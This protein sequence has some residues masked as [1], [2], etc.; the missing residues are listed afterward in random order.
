M[1]LDWLCTRGNNGICYFTLD[2]NRIPHRSRDLTEDDWD[3]LDALHD[4]VIADPQ[5]QRAASRLGIE[6]HSRGE[7]A[8]SLDKQKGALRFLEMKDRYCEPKPR[9]VRKVTV[10]RTDD[11]TTAAAKLRELGDAFVA[12][13]KGALK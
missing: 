1:C 4:D 8:T 7:E 5:S 3:A 2:P 9:A 10:F 13:L 11:A 6:I 12:A